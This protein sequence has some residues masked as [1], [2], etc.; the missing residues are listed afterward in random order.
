MTYNY[1]IKLYENA[2]RAERAHAIPKYACVL[3]ISWMYE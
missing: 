3:N 1:T 2:E